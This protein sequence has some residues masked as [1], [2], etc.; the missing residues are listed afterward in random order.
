MDLP[1]GGWLVR[2]REDDGL[3][4]RF[5]EIKI[6]ACPCARGLSEPTTTIQIWIGIV[7]QYGIDVRQHTVFVPGGLSL[8]CCQRQCRLVGCRRHCV[9][10]LKDRI[11]KSQ[12]RRF[13]I[14]SAKLLCCRRDFLGRAQIE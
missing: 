11:G 14:P 3:I 5:W 8:G 9:D 12:R 6:L 10:Y 4:S 7:F 2:V 1:S 13:A